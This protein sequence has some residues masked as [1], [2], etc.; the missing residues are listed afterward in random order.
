MDDPLLTK[1]RYSEKATKLWP[2]LAN[3]HFLFDIT[4]QSQIISGRWGKFWW[5]S[6][7]IFGYSFEMKKQKQDCTHDFCFDNKDSI[8][9]EKIHKN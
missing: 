4:K 6:Q 1:F 3:F 5:P 7:N 9:L 2:N 8:E